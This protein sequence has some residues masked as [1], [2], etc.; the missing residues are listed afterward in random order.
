MTIALPMVVQRPSPN[1]TPTPIRHDLFIFHDEEG[2]ADGSLAWLC[3]PRAQAAPHLAMGADGSNTTYQLVPLQYKAWAQC[4]FNSAGISLEI[5]GFADKLPDARLQAAAVIGAWTCL[6]YDIPPVWA[7]GGKGRGIVCHHDLGA[8]GGG[9]VDVGPVGGATWQSI[10]RYT[11]AAYAELKALPS[12]PPLALHGLPGPHEISTPPDVVP[13]PSHGGVPR[14]EPGDTHAH[15]TPSGFAAH[16][17][18]ALQS[19]LNKLLG[20]SLDVDGRFGALTATA[21]RCFQVAHGCDVDGLIGP[22]T[23]RAIDVAMA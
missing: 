11:Q 21:L 5:P 22:Q 14:N 13:E 2:N 18:A 17:I 10:V 8:A 19:D 20:T 3:D 16:S 6:A 23:W 9:H 7:P 4:S 1:Y 12:L 15:P